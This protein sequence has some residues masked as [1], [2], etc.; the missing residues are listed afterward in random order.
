MPS[1]ADIDIDYLI[2]TCRLAGA[3]ILQLYDGAIEVQLKADASPLTLADLRSQA[4][5]AERLRQ[6]FPEVPLLA[7]ENAEQAPYE[8]RRHWR[9]LWLVDPLD[10]TKEFLK[11]N[12]QFT[13]NI[14]LIEGRR[15]ALGFVYAPA[16]GKLYYGG[17]ELGA[18]R[19]EAD[20]T[21][22]RL[23]ETERAGGPR[24]IVG[25]LSHHSP[26]MDRYLEEQRRLHGE[27]EFVQMGSALKV[28]LVAEGRADVYPRLGTTMEWDTAAAHAV[29]SGAGRKLVRWGSA[30]E[31]SYNK[32]DLRNDWFIVE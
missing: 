13:V 1:S 19:L 17:P 28:C 25:S 11:R 23:P 26:E 29:A 12:G 5:I 7:E 10:G 16:L 21:R 27:I 31:L 32:E 22:T 6:A 24:R 18:F 9:A 4:I 8:V 20:G 15:P 3:A 2:E 14:A 30:E